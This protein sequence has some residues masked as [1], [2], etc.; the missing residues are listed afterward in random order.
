MHYFST[1]IALHLLD[2]MA[3]VLLLCVEQNV[4]RYCTTTILVQI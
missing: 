3:D 2:S 1:Y 4:E